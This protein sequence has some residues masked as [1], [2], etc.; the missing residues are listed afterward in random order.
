MEKSRR[1]STVDDPSSRL[2][3]IK[4]ENDITSRATVSSVR[5]TRLMRKSAA[6]RRRCW[7]WWRQYARTTLGLPCR[8]GCCHSAHRKLRRWAPSWALPTHRYGEVDFYDRPLIDPV[9]RRNVSRPGCC[10][11]E[12]LVLNG[13]KSSAIGKR[14]WK[15]LEWT[16]NSRIQSWKSLSGE[17]RDGTPDSVSYVELITVPSCFKTI[18]DDVSWGCYV[19]ICC[20]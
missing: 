16:T 20:R 1:G 2:V 13:Y 7:S 9:S 6:W 17:S 18:S 3:I 12:R 14:C 4:S 5:V 10:L 19:R 15:C 8:P 11:F